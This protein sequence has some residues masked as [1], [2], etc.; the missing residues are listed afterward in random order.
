[1]K[2]SVNDSF[3]RKLKSID[4]IKLILMLGAFPYDF[5]STPDKIQL[6]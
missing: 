3:L 6:F 1:M 4:I 5:R 2:Q